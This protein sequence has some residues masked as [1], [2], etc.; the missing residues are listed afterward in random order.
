MLIAQKLSPI[1]IYHQ[2]TGGQNLQDEQNIQ[3]GYS[4]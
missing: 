3:T 1:Q 2:A 4:R